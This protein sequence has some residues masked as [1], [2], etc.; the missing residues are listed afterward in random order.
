[1]F[2]WIYRRLHQ[3][4]GKLNLQFGGFSVVWVG[5]FTQ[6]L[7]VSDKPLYH[8]LTENTTGIMVYLAYFSFQ[9]VMKLSENQRLTS[10][11]E[12]DFRKFLLRIANGVRNVENWKL[13]CIWNVT[14]FYLKNISNRPI[15]LA[16]TNKVF[17]DNNHFVLMSFLKPI[18]T[19]KS[20]NNCSKAAKLSADEFGYLQRILQLSVIAP[21]E[22]V[23]WGSGW[24]CRHYL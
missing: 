1:M 16:Y 12:K 2:E 7:S 3:A 14:C 4:S 20:I 19:L 22:I 9:T 5:D 6:L 8:S 10:A 17:A 15:Q 11:D 13:P 18:Y 24:S 23:Y 21:V